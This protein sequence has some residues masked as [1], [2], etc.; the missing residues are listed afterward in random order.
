VSLSAARVEP[1]TTSRT[2]TRVI[3]S[4]RGVPLDLFTTGDR[5]RF[6]DAAERFLTSPEHRTHPPGPHHPPTCRARRGEASSGRP[7]SGCVSEA[8]S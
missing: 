6:D 8:R 2:A 3:A 7:A 4:I 1:Q 5:S